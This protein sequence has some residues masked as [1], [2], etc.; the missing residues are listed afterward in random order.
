[1]YT[2]SVTELCHKYTGSVIEL[3]PYYKYTESV[4]KL[5]PCVHSQ[6]DWAMPIG[7]QV[8]WLS[9]ANKYTESVTKLCPCVHRQCDWAMPI[10]I[11][12]GW[13]SYVHMYVLYCIQ[14]VWLS[15][16]HMYTGSVT[17]HITTVP[18]TGSNIITVTKV[19]FLPSTFD[20]RTDFYFCYQLPM[21]VAFNTF[22]CLLGY[23]LFH[24]NVC[25]IFFSMEIL[26]W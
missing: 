12:A 21:S 2:G 18:T 6:C 8:V 16:A 19:C 11:Q 15:Y 22:K 10:C 5:C 24:S 1:M 20:I 3:C 23:Q 14:A 25:H 26:S 7:I 13:L 9:Y 4:T 17:K